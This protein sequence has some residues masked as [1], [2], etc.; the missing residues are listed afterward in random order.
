MSD[1]I[2]IGLYIAVWAGY[3][4]GLYQWVGERWK[5]KWTNVVASVVVASVWPI[6]LGMRIAKK[7]F[8]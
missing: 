8:S 7:D 5:G 6:I 2:L 4:I 1:F 3:S